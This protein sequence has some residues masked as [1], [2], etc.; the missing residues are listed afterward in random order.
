MNYFFHIIIMINIYIVLTVSSNLLVGMTNLLSLGQAAFYG[1][2]AYFSVLALTTLNLPLIPSLIVA[3]LATGVFSL[4]LALTSL[5]LKNDY[6]VLSTL[7]FQIITF[8]VLY[9]WISVTKGPYGIPGIPAPKLLG[10]FQVSGIIPFL[11]FSTVM[12]LF[13]IFIFYYLINSPFGRLL[14][15][16]REDELA[17]ITLGKNITSLKIQTFAI[18]SSFIAIAGFLY[19]TYVTYIDPSSFNLDESIFILSALLIG[20][21]GNIKGPVVGSIFVILLPEILRF[22]GLPDSIAAN[23][24]QII[25]GLILIILM[26]FKPEGLAGNYRIK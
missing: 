16:M 1:I 10:I 17:L 8:S 24:R 12:S 6:F 9:N 3:M 23:M 11:I 22:V 21:L 14:K 4:L 20:G 2:G 5:R 15:A 18:S 13:T 26:R 19:A 25:Y 7:G